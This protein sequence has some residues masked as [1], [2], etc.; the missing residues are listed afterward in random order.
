MNMLS[1][2]KLE[3]KAILTNKAILL[4]VIGGAL[5]YSF[6]YPQP[7]KKQLPME[8]KIALIDMDKTP[9]SNKI[10]RLINAT[11]QV[12]IAMELHDLYKLK[13]LMGKR[14]IFGYIYIPKNFSKDIML[15]KSPAIAYGGNASF[16]LVYGTVVESIYEV[17][18]HEGGQIRGSKELIHLSSKPAFNHTLGYTSYVIPAVFILI[19]H[20]IMVIGVSLQGATQNEQK[21]GYWMDIE[22]FRLMMVRFLAYLIVYFPICVYYVGFCF[23]SYFIPVNANYNIILALLVVLIFA[24][25]SLGVLLG[26]FI[27]RKEHVTFLILVSSLPLV[28]SAGFVWP[29]ELLP[30]WLN[31]LVQFY[32]STP[33]ILSFV[34]LNQ[35]GASFA[36]V[37]LKVLQL[38][39]LGVSYFFLALLRLRIKTNS[40]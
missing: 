22:P 24:A 23:E 26:E 39:L 27:K 5:L 11:P 19:L 35:M 1:L 37:S 6:L 17:L 8:Q 15:K 10:A 36:Q 7:Y 3:L 25:V 20:Q 12:H 16:L 2:L 34:E 29:I 18:R 14:E 9:L 40:L 28:F 38:C 21:S 31:V 13:E 33:A 30:R 4:T 32:P